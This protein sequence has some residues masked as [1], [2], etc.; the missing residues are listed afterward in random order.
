MCLPMQFSVIDSEH[1]ITQLSFEIFIT[2]YPQ[3]LFLFSTV[4]AIS[5]TRIYMIL[6][7][8]L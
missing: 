5:C 7:G 3:N 2:F 1:V 4:A 6:R 8:L